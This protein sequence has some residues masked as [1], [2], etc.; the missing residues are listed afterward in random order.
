MPKLYHPTLP[1]EQ[2]I[3]VHAY[4]PEHAAAGWLPVDDK[5][6]PEQPAEP[7]KPEQAPAPLTSKKEN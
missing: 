5:S 3:D 7:V 4:G 6:T 1:P 2:Q